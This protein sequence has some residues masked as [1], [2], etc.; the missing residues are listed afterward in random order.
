[1]VEADCA[2]TEACMSRKFDTRRL[3]NPDIMEFTLSK[4]NPFAARRLDYILTSS[5]VFD[6]TRVQY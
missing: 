3:F 6:K 5:T 1:M 4:R 2:E